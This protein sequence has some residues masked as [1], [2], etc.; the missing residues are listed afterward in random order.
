MGISVFI[1]ACT[2]RPPPQHAVTGKWKYSQEITRHLSTGVRYYSELAPS[3]NHPEAPQ[4]LISQTLAYASSCYHGY[5]R[6]QQLS[7]VRIMGLELYAMWTSQYN[8]I[9]YVWIIGSNHTS[10]TKGDTGG[11]HPEFLLEGIP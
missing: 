5:Y 7:A 9:I 4:Q 10:P 6:Y 8:I 11:L 3:I 2:T 1:C